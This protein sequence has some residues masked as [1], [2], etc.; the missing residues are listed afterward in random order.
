M[1]IFCYKEGILTHPRLPLPQP[2]PGEGGFQPT[3]DEW[4][5]T[6]PIDISM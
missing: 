3:V 6:V 4:E 5:E 1:A 2:I